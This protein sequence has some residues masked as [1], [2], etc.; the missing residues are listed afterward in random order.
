MLPVELTDD[1]GVKSYNRSVHA[2]NYKGRI[3]GM[4]AFA[5]R[6]KELREAA[7][8]TQ[9]QLSDKVGMA[10]ST[11]GHLEQ[12]LRRPSWDTI[13]ALS[14]ALGVEC[15]AFTETPADRPP[16]G[17]GRP[18]TS[19]EGKPTAEKKPAAHRRPRRS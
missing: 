9:K 6:L 16:S 8:L 7:G 12:G 17:R 11:I 15:T 3:S 2:V 19:K 10:L 13:L 18:P 14:A 5:A 4:D 1:S